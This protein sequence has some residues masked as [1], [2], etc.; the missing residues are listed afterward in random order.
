MNGLTRMIKVS[1]LGR[2]G[3]ETK[4]VHLEEAEKILKESYADPMGGLVYD[5]RTGEVI[6]EIGPNIEEIVIM[7]H[8]IGGG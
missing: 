4:E 7:D 5:R 8:M 3:L 2:N 6:E 1:I